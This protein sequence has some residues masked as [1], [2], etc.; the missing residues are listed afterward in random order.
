MCVCVLDNITVKTRPGVLSFIS[1]LLTIER[2]HLYEVLKN[3]L[4]RSMQC[5]CLYV[6]FN[7]SFHDITW[8]LF[9]FSFNSPR[10]NTISFVDFLFDYWN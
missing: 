8:A 3:I 10:E 7:V 6:R 5:Q 1:Q 2:K 9:S 4:G